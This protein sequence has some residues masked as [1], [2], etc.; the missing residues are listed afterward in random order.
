MLLTITEFIGRFHPVLVHL[1]IGFLLIGLLLQWLSSKEKY[2]V[3]KEV[4][5]VVILSGMIT[6]ILA[7]ITGY[8]LSLS[9]DYDEDLIDWHM[10]MGIG[11]AAISILQYAKISYGQFDISHKI[12]SLALLFFILITG[13]LGGSLT[14]GPDYIFSALNAD[15]TDTIKQKAIADI[16]QADDESFINF[17]LEYGM[18]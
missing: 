4:I 9:G 1:P 18:F 13:H 6:A 16:Q 8:F 12:L 2:H 7:C 5:K 17:L 14:H 11:V 10:W 3:S 15:H